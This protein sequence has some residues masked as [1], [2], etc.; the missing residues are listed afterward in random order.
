[1]KSSCLVNI[2]NSLKKPKDISEIC[3]LNTLGRITMATVKYA[4]TY[5][6]W[7]IIYCTILLL[8]KISVLP[9]ST[10]LQWQFF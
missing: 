8:S 10:I 9:I 2:I 5:C 6:Q 4:E 7:W 3:I 1:M